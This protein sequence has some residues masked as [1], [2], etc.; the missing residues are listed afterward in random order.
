MIS[1]GC[2]TARVFTDILSGKED[3]K[4]INP[5]VYINVLNTPDSKPGNRF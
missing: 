5:D 3:F 2:T 1:K 4:M